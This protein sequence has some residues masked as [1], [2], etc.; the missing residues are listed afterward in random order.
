LTAFPPGR[1]EL[2]TDGKLE[3]FQKTAYTPLFAAPYHLDMMMLFFGVT[4]YEKTA[5]FAP[6]AF[7]WSCVDWRRQPGN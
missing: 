2:A 5:G 6:A 4:H 1:R 3:Q 7:S